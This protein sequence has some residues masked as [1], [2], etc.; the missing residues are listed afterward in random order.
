M[1]DVVFIIALVLIGSYMLVL[2]LGSFAAGA[3]VWGILYLLAMLLNYGVAIW[4]IVDS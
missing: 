2:A 1:E 3:V 4:R